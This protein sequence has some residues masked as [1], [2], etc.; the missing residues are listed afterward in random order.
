MTQTLTDTQTTLP[1][2]RFTLRPVP[3]VPARDL[4]L[5]AKRAALMAGERGS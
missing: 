1:I 2:G 3:V 5:A 4:E